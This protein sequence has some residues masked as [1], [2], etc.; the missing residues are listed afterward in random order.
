MRAGPHAVRLRLACAYK[1]ARTECDDSNLGPR[2]SDDSNQH[3]LVATETKNS[4]EE[5][6]TKLNEKIAND[7]SASPNPRIPAT[8]S[9]ERGN[10]A[11][12]KDEQKDY[13][14]QSR[15]ALPP[16]ERPIPGIRQTRGA[17]YQRFRRP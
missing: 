1:E 2:S 7:A 13:E 16:T 11:S 12:D 8:S 14:N 15:G 6:S 3:V 17:A 10:P 9:S 4:S 5:S